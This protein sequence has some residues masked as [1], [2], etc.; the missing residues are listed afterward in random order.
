M[1]KYPNI[2]SYLYCYANPSKLIDP[3]GKDPIL[4]FLLYKGTVVIMEKMVPVNKVRQAGYAMQHPIIAL[5]V[6]AYKERGTNISSIASNFQINIARAA[7]LSSGKEGDLGNAFRH[8]LWQS[9]ITNKFGE[10]NAMRIG[11]SHEDNPYV[12][13]TQRHFKSMKAADTVI[14][15]LN[16]IIGRRIGKEN[17]GAD[18]KTLAL[19]VIEEFYKKGLWVGITKDDGSVS[20]QKETITKKQYDAAV[21]NISK[22]N[23]N[24]LNE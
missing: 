15:L 23:N 12:D 24:G 13:I 2:S 6:G 3:D 21:K 18:N 14:D 8:T 7:N 9:I 19:K 16:N 17:K 5:R 1:E 10:R 20:I 11:N 4:W 22:K